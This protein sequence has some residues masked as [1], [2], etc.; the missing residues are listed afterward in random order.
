[1]GGARLRLLPLLLVV[2]LRRGGLP[3][4][5]LWLRW[6]AVL[7]PLLLRLRW[8]TVRPLLLGRLLLLLQLL[9][10]PQLLGRGSLGVLAPVQL[11][12]LQRRR[13]TLRILLV[14]VRLLWRWRLGLVLV[15][16]LMRLLVG[17][18]QMLVLHRRR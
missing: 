15:G 7:L 2:G 8:R 9:L 16:L 18:V 13:R 14:L 5:E 1:M 12:R 4:L 17:R 3:L 11:P 6:V 10:L